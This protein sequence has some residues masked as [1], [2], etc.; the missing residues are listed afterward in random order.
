[1][2]LR[3]LIVVRLFSVPASPPAALLLGHKHA[4]HFVALVLR[5][6]P[7]LEV[8]LEGVP[9]EV[10][11][12]IDVHELSQELKV[13]SLDEDVVAAVVCHLED[14]VLDRQPH[15][16]V[17]TLV[18]ALLQVTRLDIELLDF[19]LLVA[20]HLQELLIPIDS[21]VEGRGDGQV[22]VH[23]VWQKGALGVRFLVVACLVEDVYASVIAA[24]GL[25]PVLMRDER[26]AVLL[27]EALG[28][29]SQRLDRFHDRVEGDHTVLVVVVGCDEH[30]PVLYG[31]VHRVGQTLVVDG[32]RGPQFSVVGLV[33]A[34]QD[35][36]RADHTLR[37]VLCSCAHLEQHHFV[38]LNCALVARILRFFS[39]RLLEP[40]LETALFALL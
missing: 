12:T 32:L 8:V 27:P 28:R 35:L 36:Q 7:F 18:R 4:E 5:A 34:R 15:R 23:V 22:T 20:A 19:V 14:V 26:H 25:E 39:V 16:L 9:L 38:F 21:D 2:V 3:C 29:A 17:Q 24:H 1:M 30:Q 6:L 40:W 37:L 33:Y 10:H 31:Q 11:R 13:G